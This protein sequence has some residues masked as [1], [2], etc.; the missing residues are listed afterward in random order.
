MAEG[1]LE[2]ALGGEQEKPES[3]A[4]ELQARAEA[5]ASAVA[6]RFSSND[7]DVAR[8]TAEFLTDQSALLRVQ[9][10]HLEAEHAQRLHLLKGQA[11]E[12]DLRR[13]GLRLRVGFQLF[14]VLIAIVVGLGAFVLIHDAVTTR[15]V[16][17][18]PFEVARG[19]SDRGLTGTVV[20]NAVLDELTK[21]QEATRSTTQKPSLSNA[22]AKE[23]KLTVPET[24]LSL[25]EMSQL[26]KARF[27]HDIHI[28]GDL[29]PVKHDAL[30]LT[31]RGDGLTPKSFS[32]AEGQTD[33]LAI[34]AAEY[35]Y[36][37]SQPGLWAIYLLD[38]HRF[39]ETIAFSEVAVG[40][41]LP[42]E[43]AAMILNAWAEA[44]AMSNG[45]GP[46]AL[47]LVR[48]AI[49][50]QPDYWHSYDNLMNIQ[51]L[52]GDEEG[53]YTTAQNLMK[54]AGGRPGRAPEITYGSFD[55]NTYNYNA[56]LK[57]LRSEAAGTKGEGIWSYVLG[58]TIASVEI[59]LHD[60][61]SAEFA[62]STVKPDPEDPTTT[63]GLHFAL[64]QIAN[65]KG[66]FTQA[67]QEGEAFLSLYSNPAVVWAYPGQNCEIIPL[68]E[69]AGN[70]DR[71]DLILKGGGSYV[72][73][74][75]FHG[76]V[77]DGRG[78]WKGAQEWYAKSVTLAPHLPGGYYSWGIALAK[79]GD[80]AG[81]EAKQREANKRGPRWADPLKA[82][83]DVLLTQGKK[84]DALAKYDEALK[85]A[86]HWKQL[87][88]AR[89]T[90][91][92]QKS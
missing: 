57:A 19:L 84:K 79:H 56:F 52:L 68:E 4:P 42:S 15:S 8:K 25:S 44:S 24:G 47:E 26:L 11:R 65:E 89:A 17:I 73:C 3:E 88:E 82:W 39:A 70:P 58:P 63:A 92:K 7:P 27:G 35:I 48:R 64:A 43:Q 32:N 6:A 90:L 30:Q 13:L 53:T 21:I 16:L 10:R 5:F 14:L 37:R 62:T 40:S 76:D 9:R 50:Q 1:F 54:L 86:P 80:L 87:K 29:I 60:V 55:G 74:Y 59:A 51:N 69:A 91:A 33:R 38:S 36:S 72:D 83:G 28:G 49:A 81:A 66:K 23:I 31:I 22:W 34:E 67:S 78:D 61:A 20:A 18:E 45:D 77:L 12:I 75:R 2:G 85:Y 71:A 41:A 46:G